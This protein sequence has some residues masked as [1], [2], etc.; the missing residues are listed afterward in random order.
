MYTALLTF[1]LLC[2]ILFIGIHVYRGLILDA[3]MRKH[4]SSQKREFEDKIG[5]VTRGILK[6]IVTLLVLSGVGLLHFHSAAFLSFDSLFSY[7]LSIKIIFAL[8]VIGIFLAMP[9]I[10]PR[11]NVEV[12]P[13]WHLRIHYFMSF[14]MLGIVIL[15]KYIYF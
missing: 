13:K 4:F 12:R 5:P 1:H 3:I 11:I 10:M 9:Y 8:V 6:V 7:L 2:A 14:L 15:S